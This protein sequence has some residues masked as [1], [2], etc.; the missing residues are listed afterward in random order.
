MDHRVSEVP[1]MG[2]GGHLGTS[3]GSGPGGRFWGHSEAI[4]RSILVN[5]RPYSQKPHENS[6]IWPWVGPEAWKSVKYGYWEGAG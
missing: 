5:S 1:D 2:S 4:L 3:L 6:F